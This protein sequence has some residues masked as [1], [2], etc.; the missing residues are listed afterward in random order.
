MLFWSLAGS[1]EL[2]NHEKK[3]RGMG[4]NMQYIYYI[5]FITGETSWHMRGV[6]HII[7]FVLLDY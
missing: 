7:N 1:W 6:N 4:N 3:K 5:F 2:K